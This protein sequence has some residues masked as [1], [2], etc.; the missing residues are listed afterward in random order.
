MNLRFVAL[1]AACAVAAS[2]AAN[3]FDVSLLESSGDFQ[4]D[5]SAIYAAPT[6]NLVSSTPRLYLGGSNLAGTVRVVS[7]GHANGD[8][9]FTGESFL[10]LDGSIWWGSGPNDVQTVRVH[11][12]I[13]DLDNG[14]IYEIVSWLDRYGSHW[15]R[16][17]QFL[18]MTKN[19]RWE[20]TIHLATGPT[21][22]S[23]E[24][25]AHRH[26]MAM[27]QAVPEPASSAAVVIGL[28]G[29][30]ARTRRRHNPVNR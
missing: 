20:D 4:S 21:G 26:T 16:D 29:L 24:Y 11:S 27:S 17:L 9:W 3:R 28:L 13:T 23:A 8:W 14:H 19:V 30:R 10:T 5:F 1:V 12:R 25:L 7:E 15:G 6:M 2:A 22:T 18:E